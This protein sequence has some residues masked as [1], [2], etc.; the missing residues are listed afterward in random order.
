VWAFAAAP[1]VS[2]LVE[3]SALAQT[4]PGAEDDLEIPAAGARAPQAPVAPAPAA[5]PTEPGTPPAPPVAPPPAPVPP[6]ATA[7][8]VATPSTDAQ[9]IAELERRLAQL[10]ERAKA[11][12]VPASPE[13]SAAEP[14]RN[15]GQGERPQLTPSPFSTPVPRGFKISGY[16][17]ADFRHSQLSEDQL[18][19]S[20]APLNQN[21]F[22]LRRARL[23]FDRGW[24]YAALSLELDANTVDAPIVGIR[25]A[26]ASLLY[27]GNNADRLP[28]LVMV[29][30]GI[31]DLPF[32]YELY[33]S[34]RTAP[35]L[36]RSL[37][38]SA[39]FPTKADA[40]VKVSG[41]WSFLRYGVAISNGEPVDP[42]GLPRDPNAAK[43]ITGRFGV[44]TP[45]AGSVEVTG[46]ASFATGKGFRPGAPAKKSTIVWQDDNDDGSSTPDELTGVIGSAAEPSENF[47]RWA[48]GLDL[49]VRF[50]TQLGE[51]HVRG[52]VIAASN[53]DR[54]FLVSDPGDSNIDVRQLGG[55]VALTQELTRYGFAGFRYSMY[56]PNSD[57]LD[58]RR[59]R[60]EPRT[61]T[62]HTLSPMVA[63]RLP[64]RAR[65]SFQYDFIRDHLARDVSGVPT[66]AKNDQW[67][68]RLQVDL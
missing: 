1:L 36:E 9:R 3:E 57:F 35:F 13:E 7:A 19:A 56:D 5:S 54:G 2:L 37:V 22:Y 67:T 66:D 38:S 24:E 18:D 31:T 16:A 64:D 42:R 15:E 6:P 46:G 68:V 29:T 59:G 17:Q 58:S 26:E 21:R 30:A 52:E 23:R 43:D 8:P 4:P 32:G 53:Y 34:D 45:V 27:R 20:S 11:T 10:E 40:G 50:R 44:L 49:G 65:L 47:D 33:E 28:P 61:Q 63:L 41:A 60:A 55:Y 39:L 12:P 62:V 25:R 14:V 48:F 51:T